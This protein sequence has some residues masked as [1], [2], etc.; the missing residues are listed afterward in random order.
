VVG[1]L[2]CAVEEGRRRDD[3][4][5]RAEAALD[6][7]RLDERLLDRVVDPLDGDDVVPLGLRCEDEARAD[8][9][10]VEEHRARAALALLAG[11]LRAR[12][13][14]PL[15]QRV[16][17]ALALPDVGFRLAAVDA[18]RDPHASTRASAR[19]AST[20]SAWRRY[21]AVERTSSIGRAAATTAS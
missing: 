17:E 10:A 14:E 15:A 12:E 1:R 21:S 7:A 18:E 3:E 13:A 6:A 20:P 4:A 2:W 16:E 19:R 9:H 8:E 11:V 5:R